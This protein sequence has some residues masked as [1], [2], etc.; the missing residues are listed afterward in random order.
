MMPSRD[1]GV[2]WKKAS[3]ILLVPTG[4]TIKR[5]RHVV[6]TVNT[7]FTVGGGEFFIV[8]Y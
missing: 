8:P 4:E 1:I 7:I 5:N 6:I 3:A 2:L